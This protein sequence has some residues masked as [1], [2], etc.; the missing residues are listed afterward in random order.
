M[1]CLAAPPQPG[2]ESYNLYIEETSSI[3]NQRRIMSRKLLD[4]IN[5]IPGLHALEIEAGLV[6]FVKVWHANT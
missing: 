6:I 4:G 2:D 3:L 5:S 1:D